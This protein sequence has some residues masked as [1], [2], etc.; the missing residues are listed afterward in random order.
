MGG[1]A[2]SASKNKYNAKTYD[3]LS[4]VLRKDSLTGKKAIQDAATA[5]GESVNAYVI[6]ALEARMSAPALALDLSSSDGPTLAAITAAAQ[7]EGMSVN[8]WILDAIRDKL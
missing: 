7:R 3:R 1:K 4:I 6:K 2:S 8:E 5:A